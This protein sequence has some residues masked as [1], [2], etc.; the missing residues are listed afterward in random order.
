MKVPL[1]KIIKDLSREV[2][3]HLAAIMKA[4]EETKTDIYLVG[5]P[6]RDLL[7]HRNTIDIDIVV[8]EDGLKFAAF[9]AGRTGGI[10]TLH[11]ERLTA[12][13]VMPGN[14]HIDIAT[15]RTETYD[16]PGALPRVQPASDIVQDLARRDFTINAMAVRLNTASK[17]EEIIDP[18]KG[19]AD[20][21][22]SVI[23]FLHVK[24]F[25]D[26]PTRIFRAIRFETRFG[27]TIEE[28]T[29]KYLKTALSGSALKTISGQRCIKEI[30]LYLAEENPFTVIKRA[31]ELGS[32]STV[33]PDAGVLEEIEDIFGKIENEQRVDRGN[34]RVLMLTALFLHH[35]PNEITNLSSYF[36]MTK[37]QRSAII[38][39]KLLLNL[40]KESPAMLDSV[41]KRYSD[42][43]R[44]LAYLITSNKSLLPHLQA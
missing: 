35:T 43:A 29:L 27:F 6:L 19:Y 33:I 11:K 4:A 41:I 39:T 40:L 22:S 9:L 24:S 34:K 2:Q 37:K 5:G 8:R 30:N 14:L 10:L 20:L 31:Y 26:D 3:E 21:G 13:I 23:R 42:H 12:S 38:D 1:E 17:Q 28:Q 18:F 44:M 32:M 36:G 7:L 15:M 25:V 16:R